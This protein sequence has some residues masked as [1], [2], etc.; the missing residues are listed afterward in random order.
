MLYTTTLIFKKELKVDNFKQKTPNWLKE[1]AKT[2]KRTWIP[3]TDK[4]KRSEYQGEKQPNFK[5][6][7]LIDPD[8]IR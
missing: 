4:K 7:L 5:F 8:K 3:I 6:A 1:K 2:N